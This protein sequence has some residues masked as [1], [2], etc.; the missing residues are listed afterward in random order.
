MTSEQLLTLIISVVVVILGVTYLYLYHRKAVS[1][2]GDHAALNVN[3][4]IEALGGK[5]NIL[6]TSLDNKRLK[7]MLEDPKLVSQTLL[8]TMDIAGFLSGKELKLLIKENPLEVKRNL[9]AIR[10]EV[11]L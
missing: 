4:L 10:N 3:K 8:K 1:I 5:T 7:V 9:D 2:K 6:S 11:R